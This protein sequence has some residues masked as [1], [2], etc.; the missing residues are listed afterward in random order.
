MKRITLLGL[1]LMS[2]FITAVLIIPS[3]GGG[4][5]GGGISPTIIPTSSQSPSPSPT[6][7]SSNW[8]SYLN[9]LRSLSN[10]PPVLEDAAYDSGN[11]KHARYMVKNDIIIHDEDPSNA[12]YTAEGREAAQSSDLFATSSATLHYETAIDEWMTGPFHG[13]G[14]IDPRLLKSGYG[15][16]SEADGSIQSAAGL[17]VIRGLGAVPSTVQ[18][19]IMWPADGKTLGYSSYAGNEYPDPLSNSGYTAPT[20]PPIYLQ[21]GSGTVTPSVTAHTFKSGGVNLDHIIFDETTYTNGDISQQ[22]LGRNVLHARSAIVLM[23]KTPLTKGA[24][25]EVSITA[26]GATHTWSFIVDTNAKTSKKSKEY[27]EIK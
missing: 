11:E 27:I 22:N 15:Q 16:Y 23:P 20:G 2:L 6:S 9:Y 19:P 25:Y 26:N 5:G 21:L 8:L 18:Y 4:G 14:L 24:T 13:I 17:D 3:C 10:L 7:T 1:I 12:Y